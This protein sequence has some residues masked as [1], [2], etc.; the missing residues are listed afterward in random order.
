MNRVK[1]V[2]LFAFV[3]FSCAKEEIKGKDEDESSIIFGHFYGFCGGEQC[4]ENF[5]LT[6]TKLYEETTDPYSLTPGEGNF[7]ELDHVKFEQVKSL[8]SM[9]PQQLLQTTAT[10]I[11]QPDA[12]DGGGIY[13][14]TTVNGERKFWRI[15]K[16]RANLPEYLIPFVQ[17]IEKDIALLQN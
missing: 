13:F 3:V 5:K 9:I 11:G 12:A 6:N 15:D 4:I 16:V 17:E 7:V 10:F 8:A 1:W 2:V 14:E